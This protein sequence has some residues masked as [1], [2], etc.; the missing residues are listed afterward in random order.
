M[1]L[2]KQLWCL[3]LGSLALAFLGSM[4]VGVTSARDMMQTQLRLKNNDNAAALALALSQ[5]RGDAELMGLLMAAQFDTGFYRRVRLLSVDGR[6]VFAREANASPARAPQWFVDALRID[7]LPGQA[8]VSDGWRALG[9]LQVVSHTAYAHDE[10]WEG[11]LRIAAA[12]AAV[13]LASALMAAGLVRRIRRP[14]DQAVSQARALVQGEFVS[15]PESGVPELQRLTRAMNSMVA[16]LKLVFESQAWQVETLRRQALCDPVTG[17]STRGHFMAQF[18]ATLDREDGSAEGGLVLLRVMDL[19]GLN[20][21]IGHAGADRLLLSVAQ[22][23]KAYSERVNGCHVGRL[24]GADFAL[25]LPVGGVALETAQALMQALQAVLPAFGPGAAAAAGA[26]EMQRDRK[27]GLLLSAADAALALAESRG[28]FSVELGAGLAHSPVHGGEAAWR[29]AIFKA[30]VDERV[31]L[32]RFPV[33]DAQRELVHLECPLRLQLEPDGPF[34]QAA[35]WLPLALRARL[36]ASV[37]E[38]ALLMALAAIDKD[39]LPRCVNLS[40]ASLADSTFAARLR[41][42]L[43]SSP[44]AAA[45]VSMEVPEAAAISH[46]EALKE[47]SNQVR[48][49]GA[50]LGLEHAGERLER[51]DRLYDLGLAYVKLDATFV[52]ALADDAPRRLLLRSIVAMLH[53]LSL[54]VIAEGVASPTDADALWALGFDALT[55]PWASALRT[56][57]LGSES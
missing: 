57:L 24:N 53:G 17:L 52:T 5:Q 50:S 13:G 1:S 14:L 55:G 34:E 12:L 28:P 3:L 30:L 8:Q 10:L 7:S 42:L 18:A 45:K 26:V 40:T 15:I 33:I 38:Q 35:R 27:P 9:T 16:R 37:D 36:T 11:T 19:P 43:E 20:Q 47:L 6:P 49:H 41:A 46:F 4:T 22:A 39:G 2:I 44:Q 48:Q 23:L 32:V 25:C 31:Q 29:Q 51:I 56:D 21:A 54:K